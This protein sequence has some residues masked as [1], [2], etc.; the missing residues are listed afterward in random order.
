MEVRIPESFYIK[1]WLT[2][3]LLQ[4]YV[5]KPGPDSKFPLIDLL[6]EA[7]DILHEE[8]D[9]SLSPDGEYDPGF[10]SSFYRYPYGQALSS[11]YSDISMWWNS[12]IRCFAL[13]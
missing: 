7:D 6:E 10:I 5:Q 13:V 8:H 2:T 3:F 1:W 11:V 9:Y 4:A 12:L